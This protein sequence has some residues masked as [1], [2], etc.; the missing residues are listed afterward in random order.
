MLVKDL[1]QYKFVPRRALKKETITFMKRL[2]YDIV[3][4]YVDISIG[5][6]FARRIIYS[7]IAINVIKLFLKK[8]DVDDSISCNFRKNKLFDNDCVN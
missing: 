7:K 2:E 1:L 8:P 6:S 5:T 4:A 3:F